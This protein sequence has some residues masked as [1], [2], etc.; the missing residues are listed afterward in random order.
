M[1][2]VSHE[3]TFMKMYLNKPFEIMILNIAIQ[4]NYKKGDL[5]THLYQCRLH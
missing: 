3:M 1:N 5:V 4:C 2:G